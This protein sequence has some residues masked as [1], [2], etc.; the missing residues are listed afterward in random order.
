M[1]KLLLFL[2]MCGLSFLLI[3][4]NEDET[5]KEFGVIVEEAEG[6]KLEGV[7]ESFYDNNRKQTNFSVIYKKPDLIKVR[8]DNLENADTQ[9]ILKNAEGV[10]ILIPAVNKNF[11]INSSWPMNAS[12]PYLLQSLA[13]DIASDDAPIVTEDEKTYTI[14]TKTKMHKDAMPITEKI[15]F[16]K[17]TKLP[18]EVLIYDSNGNL[19]LRVVFTKIDLNYKATDDEFKLTTSMETIRSTYGEDGF[20]YNNKREISYPTYF[21]EGVT[22]AGEETMTSVDGSMTTSLMKYQGDNS[23]SLIQ[24]FVYDTERSTYEEVNGDI[25]MVLGNAAI[26]GGNYVTMYHEGILYTVASS[27]V[28]VDEMVNIVGSYLHNEEK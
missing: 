25:I 21:P 12:Y 27:K 10:Y 15:I 19:Y 16:D 28:P 18:T 11:K 14:S 9:I 1:K 7:I 26:N 4:C 17:E 5:D 2:I 23:F 13:S 20:V 8:I 3:G 6:Y 24:E 22:L